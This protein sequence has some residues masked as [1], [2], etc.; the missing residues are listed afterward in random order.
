MPESSFLRD[1]GLLLLFGFLG[2]WLAVR[3]GQSVIIG[4]ILIGAVLG[5]HALGVIADAAL[6][7]TLA[8]L[9]I[10]LLMFFLGVEFSLERL[11]RVRAAVLLIGI[12]ELLA[13]LSVGFLVGYA[14]GWSL[15]ERAFLAGIV[16]MS[17]SGV[18]AK[19]LIEW[20]RTANPEAEALMG[21]MIF[22]DFIAVLYLG[23]LAGLSGEGA[24]TSPAVVSLLK[25]IAFYAL[26]LGFGG[27]GLARLLTLALRVRSEELFALLWLALIALAGVGASLFGLAPAAG[28]FLLGMI[29][30]A[31]QSDLGERI[32]S[33]LE[34]FRD[35]FLALFFL[36]FGTMLEG[37]SLRR[38][39]P[40]VLLIAPLS[41]LTELMVT[42]S[43]A[44]L[45]GFSGSVA[46]AIGA[47]MI[48]RGEYAL[49]Y[50]AF[51][52]Q[53][54][55]ISSDLFQ[56]TGWYVFA[57]TLLA[58]V[59]MKNTRALYRLLHRFIPRPIAF[60]GML[61]SI[62]LRPMTLWSVTANSGAT[63]RARC[64]PARWLLLWGAIA[65]LLLGALAARSVMERALLSAIG[66]V[67][68]V[69]LSRV[70]Q[71]ALEPIREHLELSRLPTPWADPD[72]VIAYTARVASSVPL[73]A[74]LIATWWKDLGAWT[75]LGI[76]LL[77]LIH[78]GWA[79]TWYR[80]WHRPISTA[81]ESAASK[82]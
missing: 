44:F 7:R 55:L 16:A 53:L 45:A 46:L 51:G 62:T 49:L 15:M 36:T 23:V 20:R 41:I 79:W 37:E 14:L 3:L 43:L 71:R 22:E 27:R 40:L 66:V 75:L 61:I 54:G 30:P 39:L 12:G 73:V 77:A 9:G 72:R 57:M 67:V 63:S 50:A 8:E 13:N 28:A 60:A 64:G 42:S 65:L 11:R 18:V 78:I 47:G 69:H 80:A 76:P 5:P 4:Y 68:L 6:M 1:L 24:R 70:M 33:R 32:Y 19:L 31:R 74:L 26:I 58:P 29:A 59:F 10:V 17:S 35:V 81:S 38:V 82:E 34:S 2:A 56:F 21:I 25:A 52:Q 48:P